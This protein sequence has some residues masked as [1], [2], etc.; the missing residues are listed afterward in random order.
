MIKIREGNTK[1]NEN[2]KGDIEVRLENKQ[3]VVFDKYPILVNSNEIKLIRYQ[4]Q[5]K[6]DD[7]NSS[8]SNSGL[9][10]KA[11]VKALEV[12]D[13]MVDSTKSLSND[14]KDE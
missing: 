7:K 11:K 4:V 1:N 8:S 13:S 12:K 14:S 10:D 5:K 2:G 6:K 3:V 9:L